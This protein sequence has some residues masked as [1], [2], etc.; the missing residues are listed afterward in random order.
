MIAK[1]K[2]ELF[3]DVNLLISL[4]CLLPMLETIHVLIK[5]TQKRCVCVW[6]CCS[7]QDLWGAIVLLLFWSRNKVHVW[8]FQRVPRFGCLQSQ[9]CTSKWRPTSLDFNMLEV[10]YLCFEPSGYTF[11]VTCLNVNGK[12]V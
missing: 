11:W 7:H 6:L 4:S 8:H 2:S 10:E 1:V 12:K 5:S 9:H 3:C